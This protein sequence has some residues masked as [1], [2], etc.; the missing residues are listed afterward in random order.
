MDL[1][2]A[3]EQ[4]EER[5][6]R[7]GFEA[8]HRG[9]S[10]FPFAVYDGTRAYT[11]E[12]YIPKPAEFIANTAVRYNGEYVA[13][14]SLTE[15]H[16][17]EDVLASKL[18]HEMLHARQRAAG[19][20]RWADERGA[21]VKY[22]CD[23]R[24]LTARLREAELM[25]ECL[26]ADAPEA[27][28]RLL[29]LRKARMEAFPYE[30]DYE[31]RIEQ[32]EGTAHHVELN[33]LRQLDAGKAEARWEQLFG[34]IADPEQYYPVRAVTYLTGA[35]MIACLKKYTEL[36]TDRL[37]DTPFSVAALDGVQPCEMPETDPRVTQV[38]ENARLRTQEKIDRAL[39]KGAP[40]LEGDW[41][42]M[43]WNVYDGTWDGKY[44]VLTYFLGYLGWDEPLPDTEEE[45][46]RQ[47]KTLQGDF[48]AE[49]DGD[50]HLK[51]VWKQ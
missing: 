40:V 25:R 33:A 39:Q 10:R 16:Y 26:T 18:V 24:N 44:A 1:K 3:Y 8:L 17:D 31:A 14:W 20:T 43:A 15:N 6:D 23:E 36:D 5:L 51:R 30:Y 35:A 46:F 9:F 4:I 27:F 13:I 50:F 2:E 29:R 41:R 12:G 38:L 32:I 21:M 48:I 49:V 22:R 19:D 37:C 47:M 7:I 28:A 34:Q 45:L 42:L 11:R